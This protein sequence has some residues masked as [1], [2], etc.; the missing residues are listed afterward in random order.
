MTLQ[1]FRKRTLTGSG[2]NCLGKVLERGVWTA[3]TLPVKPTMANSGRT[4]SWKYLSPGLKSCQT[5]FTEPNQEETHKSRVGGSL[6][7][8]Q[9]GLSKG[10]E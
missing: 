5:G 9:P 1:V 7:G 8:N 3:H 4:R 10:E 2:T 6:Q